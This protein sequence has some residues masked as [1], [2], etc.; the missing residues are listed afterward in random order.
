MQTC[1]GYKYHIYLHLL[2]KPDNSCYLFALATV[3]GA[4]NHHH[5]AS[6]SAPAA[7]AAGDLPM[8]PDQPNMH[9]AKTDTILSLLQ[10]TMPQDKV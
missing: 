4:R 3:P 1:Q 6:C 7:A 8:L 5:C 2:R 10:E 9:R